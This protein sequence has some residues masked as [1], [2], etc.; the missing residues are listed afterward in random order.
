MIDLAIERFDLLAYVQE[1]GGA[2]AQ[3]QRHEWVV[4]CPVC[5]KEK[6]VVNLQRKAWHCWV[7]QRFEVQQTILGPKRRSVSGAGGLID[8]IQLLDRCDRKR[9]VQMVLASGI[10]SKD[11]THLT[12]AAWATT[13]VVSDAPLPPIQPPPHW[14]PILGQLPYMQQRGISLAD[15]KR[16]G[17]FWCDRGRYAERLVFPVWDDGKLVYWQARAMWAARPG[18]HYVKAIN[19]PRTPGAAVSSEVLM[20]LHQAREYPRVCVTEGPVDAVHAGPDAV[21]SFGKTLSPVQLN[22]LWRAGVRALDLMYDADARADMEGLAPLLATL[23][24]LRLVYLPHGDPG[25]WP[26]EALD[27]LRGY[28]VPVRPRSMLRSV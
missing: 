16:L 2:Q 3:N 6:L 24:D 10:T 11:L 17:M 28:A 18:E 22:R 5:G 15:A 14:R 25:S 9:A 20:N 12:A 13:D 23:F 19:P 21:C 27:H 1:H 8:L 4:T 26:R 7:C